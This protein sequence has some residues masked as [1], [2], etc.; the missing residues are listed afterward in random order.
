M[1]ALSFRMRFSLQGVYIGFLK[2]PEKGDKNEVVYHVILR[3]E[4][5]VDGVCRPSQTT[6]RNAQ[7]S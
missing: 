1:I 3:I 5:T 7:S 4:F 6:E 2:N